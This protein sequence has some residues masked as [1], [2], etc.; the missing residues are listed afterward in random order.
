MSAL[1]EGLEECEALLT[2]KKKRGVKSLAAMSCAV[3]AFTAMTGPVVVCY[4]CQDGIFH[5]YDAGRGSLK[6]IF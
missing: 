6:Q 1:G 2:N 3:L 5:Q 4:G